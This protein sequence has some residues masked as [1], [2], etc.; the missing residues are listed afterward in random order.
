MGQAEL[1]GTYEQR[2]D[3]AIKREEERAMCEQINHNVSLSANQK[4][5]HHKW[6]PNENGNRFRMLLASYLMASGL[7]K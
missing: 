7:N 1:R 2:K 6:M 5:H 4:Q 3:A